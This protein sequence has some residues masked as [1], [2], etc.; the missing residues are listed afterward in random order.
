MN[1]S[2]VIK[3]STPFPNPEFFS[4]GGQRRRGFWRSKERLKDYVMVGYLIFES[5]MIE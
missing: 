5:T 1:F 2:N 4:M 3:N